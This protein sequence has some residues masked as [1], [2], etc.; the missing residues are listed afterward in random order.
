MSIKL[1]ALDVDG[2]MTDGKLYLTGSGE[3]FK[4]FHIKDGYA[5]AQLLPQTSI[6]AAI[7]TGRSSETVRFRAKE[8]GIEYV[9]ENIVDKGQAF[10]ELALK[11][12]IT[13]DETA[14]LGDDLNDLSAID[15]A[16]ISACP[17]DAAEE[18]RMVCDYVCK[19]SG[20]YGAVR[21][22]IELLIKREELQ[23]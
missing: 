21:E 6:Q 18:V 9:L 11:L 12:G 2:T 7:I 23:R 22:F 19:A 16:G 4:V 15:I 1:L 10:R 13:M 3:Y 20:G 17:A 14:Y 8:L 5:L